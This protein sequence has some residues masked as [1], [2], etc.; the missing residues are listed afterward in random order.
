MSATPRTCAP[1]DLL[2]RAL[3]T[4]SA[5]LSAPMQ[6]ASTAGAQP[7]GARIWAGRLAA[8]SQ[9]GRTLG[10]KA[11][12]PVLRMFRST[13]DER[14]GRRELISQSTPVRPRLP[15]WVSGRRWQLDYNRP[16]ERDRPG[17]AAGISTAP[18][19]SMPRG[20][21]RA[22]H[23]QLAARNR[24]GAGFGGPGPVTGFSSARP[25]SRAATYR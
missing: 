8:T 10:G 25:G 18:T 17:R 15:P 5:A 4:A 16:S 21:R 12:G 6:R 9:E 3:A 13:G 11:P 24:R 7:A 20:H 14:D 22:G 23:V 19:R 2:R 1:S